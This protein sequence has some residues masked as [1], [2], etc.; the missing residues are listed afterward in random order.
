MLVKVWYLTIW[1]AV[2]GTERHKGVPAAEMYRF[3]EGN[4]AARIRPV[5]QSR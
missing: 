1:R 4:A 5:I 2:V 3:A